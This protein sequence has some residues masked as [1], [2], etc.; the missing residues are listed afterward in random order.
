[1]KLLSQKINKKFYLFIYKSNKHFYIQIRNNNT[2][3]IIF[4][5]STLYNIFTLKKQLIKILIICKIIK[6]I[7][8]NLK[9]IQINFIK[10]QY[11]GKLI[12]LF[13][14]NIQK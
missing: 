10:K 3:N 2:N 1:M 13:I 7:I 5:I 11:F 14:K 8:N 12:K 9:L 6:I 4:S